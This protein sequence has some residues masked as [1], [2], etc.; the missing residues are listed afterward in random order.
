[1]FRSFIVI[2]LM[3][4][5]G[6]GECFSLDLE[7][8]WKR[9]QAYAPSIA[10][11]D[12]KIDARIAERRQV[13]L[14]PN[15]VAVIEA[16]NLGVSNHNDDAEPPETTFALSQ[17]IELG[18]KRSA[19]TLFA[20]SLADIAFW[21]AQIARSD[22]R[23]ALT[24]AFIDVCIAQE[25]LRLAQEKVQLAEE[26]LQTLNIQVQGGKISPIQQKK[27]FLMQMAAQVSVREAFSEFDQAK[28]RLSSLWGCP[29]PDF[30]CVIYNLFEC[31]PPPGC[32]WS[33]DGIPQTPEFA[34]AYAEVVS[35]TQNL[36][37]QRANGIPD[38]VLTVG[39]SVF[40]DSNQHGWVV[41]VEVPLPFFD[42][43]QG[44]IQKACVEQSQAWYQVEEVIRSLKEQILVVH[45]RL[46][47]AFEN[48]E[49]MRS[50]ILVEATDTFNLIQTGYT[51]GKIEYLELLDAQNTLFEIQEK[52]TEILHDYHF[53]RA[54]LERLT[55]QYL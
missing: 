8:A 36:K 1:M 11:A 14:F 42:R 32:E 30:D 26:V 45:N 35:A 43:N 34:R 55:G 4:Q 13:A 7:T 31:S 50:E 23:F 25:R 19:R 9:I 48:S 33:I 28:K 16:E 29:D 40:N 27:A 2:F 38:M 46:V 39:Y 10:A 53:N 44:N 22:L 52:Y 49:M 3:G 20:S 18:G 6:L 51:N 5:I 21:D 12:A 24:T 37:L 41:G 54:E 15:P 47:S 17:L